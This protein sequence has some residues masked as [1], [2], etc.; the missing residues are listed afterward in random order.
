MEDDCMPAIEKPAR[1]PPWNKGKLVGANH[2]FG[3]ATFGRSGPSCKCRASLVILP[4]ST[5][6]S[7]ASCAVCD[8]VA[9]RVDDIAPNGYALDR[10]RPPNCREDRHLMRMRGARRLR[11]RTNQSSCEPLGQRSP[12]ES[13]H[14]I[15]TVRRRQ[16]GLLRCPLLYNR[17]RQSNAH[18]VALAETPKRHPPTTRSDRK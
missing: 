11:L 9:I 17:A 12:F 14:A 10:D 13:G 15:R 7:I 18:A 4:C 5:W 8:V 3:R 1:R 6:R 2:L 16:V